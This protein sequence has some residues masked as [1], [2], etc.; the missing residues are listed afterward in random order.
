LETPGSHTAANVWIAITVARLLVVALAADF[1][2]NVNRFSLH[3]VYRNRLIRAFL[4]GPHDPGRRADGFTG[5]DPS[6]NLRVHQLW[7]ESALEG[8]DWRPF[9]VI[10]MTLNLAATTKL[11]WRQRKAESFVVTPQFCGCASDELGYRRT[12]EYGNP[13]DNGISVGTAMAISD[14]VV[15][16]NMGYHS[17]PSIGAEASNC[18]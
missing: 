4:G 12:K 16:P 11:A 17:S 8:G 1:L 10:N 7:D 14:A 5:F 15:S 18:P 3:A 2:V 9:H 6:H 13:R